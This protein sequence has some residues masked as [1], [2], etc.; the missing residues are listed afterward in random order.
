[1]CTSNIGIACTVSFNVKFVKFEKF[2]NRTRRVSRKLNYTE[3][4]KVNDISFG[5]CL[6]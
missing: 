3:F 1:M 5:A 2:N 4:S 6:P